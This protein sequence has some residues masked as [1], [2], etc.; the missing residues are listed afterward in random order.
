MAYVVGLSPE[1]WP[2]EEGGWLEFLGGPDGPVLERRS[3]GWNTLDLFDV[4]RPGRWHRVPILR[5]H[6]ARRTIAGWFHLAPEG[7]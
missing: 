6:R 2:A 4:R 3:P 1:P 5:E 7:S